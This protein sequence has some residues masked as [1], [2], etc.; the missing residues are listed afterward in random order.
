MV[1]K[2]SLTRPRYIIATENEMLVA[3][4]SRYEVTTQPTTRKHESD[5]IFFLVIV[6][7]FALAHVDKGFN[8][9]VVTSV[10]HIFI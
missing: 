8:D 9:I 10:Q 6:V 3:Q 1:T 4:A 5:F 2:S 7:D